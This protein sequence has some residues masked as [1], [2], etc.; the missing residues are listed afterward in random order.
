MTGC[1]W[2]RDVLFDKP[3]P[4]RLQGLK[5]SWS[6]FLPFQVDQLTP[7]LGASGLGLA[8]FQLQAHPNSLS[9]ALE[10]MERHPFVLRIQQSV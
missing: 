8:E 3:T 5:R 4:I 1:G 9:R 6:A 2:T 7:E 10:S